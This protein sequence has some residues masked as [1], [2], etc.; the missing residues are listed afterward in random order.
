MTTL[1]PR[2]TRALGQPRVTGKVND[3][4]IVRSLLCA[5]LAAV[6]AIMLANLLTSLSVRDPLPDLIAAINRADVDAVEVTLVDGP[7]EWQAMAGWLIATDA[8]LSLNG[9]R[10]GTAGKTTCQ[11]HFGP[12]WFFNRAA[13]PEVAETGR[14][15]TSLTA[16][17]SGDQLAITDWPVPPGLKA[18]DQPFRLWAMQLHPEEAALIWEPLHPGRGLSTTMRIDQ[19]SGEARL[20][21]L[22]EY[23]A[24]LNPPSL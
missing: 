22:E 1:A 12:D 7:E 20:G 15:S 17:I 13:P 8:E 4:W 14:F 18:V 6:A 3:H 5:L 24:F 10:A 16:T 9:C 11:V 21:L 23:L 2:P 19:A